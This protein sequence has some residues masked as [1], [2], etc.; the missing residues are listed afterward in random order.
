MS[1]LKYFTFKNLGHYVA[2]IARDIV[3]GSDRIEKVLAGADKIEQTIIASG[4]GGPAIT[5]LA[6]TA[7][8]I[9]RASSAALGYLVDASIKVVAVADGTNTLTIEGITAAEVADFQKLAALFHAHAAKNGQLL[10]ALPVSLTAKTGVPAAS[11]V[12][13]QSGPPASP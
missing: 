10:P 4:V 11:A 12:G 6:V 1:F 8:E 5:A 7:E 2:V 9:T 3:N 13:I